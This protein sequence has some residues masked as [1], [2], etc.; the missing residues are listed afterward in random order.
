MGSLAALV[1]AVTVLLGI[2]LRF[3]GSGGPQSSPPASGGRPTAQPSPVASPSPGGLSVSCDLPAADC[4]RALPATLDA[5]RSVG[6]PP[7]H[8]TFALFM[9]C[10]QPIFLDGPIAGF[11]LINA[12]AHASQRLGHAVVTFAGVSRWAYLNLWAGP[13][14]TV[15][16]LIAVRTQPAFWDHGTDSSPAPSAFDIPSPPPGGISRAAAIAIAREH[17]TLYTRVVAEAG[18]FAALNHDA[19]IGLVVK[20]DLLVWAVTFQGTMT[21]CAPPPVAK[22]ATGVPGV[23]TAFLDY[24][25]GDF[26]L[27]GGGSG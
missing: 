23:A 27:G 14:S 17:I 24:Y 11:C 22:C 16:D 15:A 21:V 7:A 8:V 4:L 18:T 10:S 12:P 26:I 25:T 3:A 13:T 19:N 5:V 2:G 1:I 9:L 20:P 6:A